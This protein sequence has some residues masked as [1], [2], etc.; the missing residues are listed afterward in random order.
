MGGGL[1]PQFVNAS[2]TS[3]ARQRVLEACAR[4]TGAR[5]GR[6]TARHAGGSDTSERGVGAHRQHSGL[7]WHAELAAPSATAPTTVE[8]AGHTQPAA[9][10]LTWGALATPTGPRRPRQHYP[11]CSGGATARQTLPW[12]EARPSPMDWSTAR[13][14]LRQLPRPAARRATPGALRLRVCHGMVVDSSRNFVNATLHIDGTVTCPRRPV[15]RCHG[16]AGPGAPPLDTQGWQR[17]QRAWCWSTPPAPRASGWHAELAC[18]GVPP[19]PD[20]GRAGGHHRP[21]LPAS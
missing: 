2:L 9:A 18:T 20:H 12:A 5:P 15:T 4:A 10:E 16:T 1:E 6:T 21:P 17:H 7:Q 8:Q 14:R 11:G 19:R 13:R 3:T